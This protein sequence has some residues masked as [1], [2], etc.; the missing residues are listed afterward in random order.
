MIRARLDLGAIVFSS[1]C[2]GVVPRSS[3]VLPR[4]KGSTFRGAF[5]STL[6]QIACVADDGDCPSC[7][8]REG[9]VYYYVFE[10]PPPTDT[11]MMRKYPFAPHPFVLEPP[12]GD[13]LRYT[14]QDT[15]R[16]GLKL[17]GRAADYLPYFV[18]ALDELG[19]IGIGKG[20]GKYRLQSILSDT[21]SGGQVLIY[22]GQTKKLSD[23]CPTLSINGECTLPAPG[24]LALAFA[25]PTRIRFGEKL[26]L[27]LE[28]HMLVRSLLRRASMLSYFHCGGPLDAD[29]AGLIER[30]GQVHAVEHALTWY[31]WQRYSARQERKMRL[32]GFVGRVVFEGDLAEFLP[33]V[34]LGAHLHVGKGTSF[35]LGRYSILQEA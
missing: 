25:T 29:Y 19:R 5:G 20:R 2:F 12:E 23:R 24:R 28:F 32:G 8:V 13:Q 11:E 9:C 15:L 6:K 16:V 7:E 31:D 35:G 21:P 1:L 33:L 4:Y 26:V 18:C 22:D 3:L 27:D 10:T 14:D 17:I 34:T 30:A